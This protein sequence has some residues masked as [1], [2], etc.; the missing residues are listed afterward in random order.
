MFYQF[1][2]SVGDVGGGG[3]SEKAGGGGREGPAQQNELMLYPP[4]YAPPTLRAFTCRRCTTR[5]TLSVKKMITSFRFL[6]AWGGLLVLFLPVI[7]FG[8]FF[9]LDECIRTSIYVHLGQEGGLEMRE[10]SADVAVFVRRVSSSWQSAR[11]ASGAG[12]RACLHSFSC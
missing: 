12:L 10:A 7:L 2:F 11:G 5:A 8:V 1:T 4:C 3:G 6:V 9:A